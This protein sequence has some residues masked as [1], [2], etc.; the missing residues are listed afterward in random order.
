MRAA[1]H[2]RVLRAGLPL[3]A[4]TLL[5]GA[6]SGDDDEASVF[7]IKPGECFLAPEDVEAQ[8]SDLEEVSCGKPHDHE[9]YAVVRFASAGEE[10]PSDEFPGDEALTKFADGACA[11]EFKAYVGVDYLD[12]TLFYTYLLPSARS[13]QEDDRSVICLIA[14]TGEQREDSVKG[15]KL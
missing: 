13:W 4:T 12:S 7:S 1:I 3:L 10:E 6:C 14:A 15:S 5:L 2:R 9:A 11:Q 8:I